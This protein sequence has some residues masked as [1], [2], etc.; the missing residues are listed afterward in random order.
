M[1]MFVWNLI[2]FQNILQKTL[3]FTF[4][5][6]FNVFYV[7]EQQQ[8]KV[9]IAVVCVCLFLTV[10][11]GLADW[12]DRLIAAGGAATG[13]GPR[14]SSARRERA[15]FI[16]LSLSLSSILILPLS[17]DDQE[18]SQCERLVDTEHIDIF[19]TRPIEGVEQNDSFFLLE[20]Q[21]RF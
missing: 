21:N 4:L 16:Q 10:K 14:L 6:L 17:P 8:L 7:I 3:F 15:T 9:H 2:T 5:F 13:I 12:S 19:F 18:C 20:S 11:R 1:Q